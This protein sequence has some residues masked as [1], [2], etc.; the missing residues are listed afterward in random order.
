[1]SFLRLNFKIF[2]TILSDQFQTTQELRELTKLQKEG[3]DVS[4]RVRREELDMGMTESSLQ[5]LRLASGRPK[6]RID[7]LLREAAA[8]AAE[9]D[10]GM[11]RFFVVLMK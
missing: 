10:H 1:M 4:F 6:M 9:E 11:L 5:E 2:L 8:A 7:A 3:Y